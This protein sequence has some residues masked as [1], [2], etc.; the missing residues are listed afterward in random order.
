[1]PTLEYFL[2]AESVSVDQAT[3]R[4]SV[5]NILEEIRTF[6]QPAGVVLHGGLN[7]LVACSSWNIAQ[8]DL[9]QSFQVSLQ[10]RNPGRDPQDLM[11][12]DFVGQR[13]RQRLLHILMGLPALEVG[14]VKFELRLNGEYV[15]SHTI[16]VSRLE[17]LPE[18]LRRLVEAHVD[19]GQ[20]GAELASPKPDA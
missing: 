7:Q 3:N 10:L 9:G 5:F 14:D 2:I 19:A 18:Q 16:T 6:P 8:A 12:L 13:P 20:S 4:L 15:A 11:S 1:M 17:Q